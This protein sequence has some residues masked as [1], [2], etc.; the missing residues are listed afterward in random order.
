MGVG[1]CMER[2]VEVLLLQFTVRTRSLLLFGLVTVLG[3]GLEGLS[4]TQGLELRVTP[5]DP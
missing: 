2:W 3:T 4:S 1:E 5:L